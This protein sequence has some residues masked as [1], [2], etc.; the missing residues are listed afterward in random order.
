MEGISNCKMLCFYFHFISFDF[1][2]SI[3]KPI[4]FNVHRNS[5]YD[6]HNSAQ[7]LDCAHVQRRHELSKITLSLPTSPILTYSNAPL[8]R[9]FA[10]K[11]DSCHVSTHF[12]F[13]SPIKTH[14]WCIQKSFIG[15]SYESAWIGAYYNS[16]CRIV[17]SDVQCVSGTKKATQATNDLRERAQICVS[18]HHIAIHK[19]L[20]VFFLLSFECKYLMLLPFLNR[21]TSHLFGSAFSFVAVVCLFY[22]CFYFLDSV[23]FFFCSFIRFVSKFVVC[24]LHLSRQSI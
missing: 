4:Q 9:R 10:W 20:A 3:R 6:V 17:S 8:H 16:S 23:L 21:N 15:C 12:L 5:L 22:V 11:R 24:A 13:R 2:F 18:V 1:P 7:V 14:R 19:S